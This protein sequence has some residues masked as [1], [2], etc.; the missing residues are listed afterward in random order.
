[1]FEVTQKNELFIALLLNERLPMQDLLLKIGGRQVLLDTITDLNRKYRGIME[2]SVSGDPEE[3][4]LTVQNEDLF[5]AKLQEEKD[6]DFNDVKFRMAFLLHELLK[7]DAYLN[8]ND[9]AETMNVSRGTVN[10]DVKKLKKTLEKYSCRIIG[11]PN[12]GIHFE[13]EEFHKRLVL[14]YEVFDFMPLARTVDRTF[15]EEV[16]EVAVHYGLSS[17]NTRLLYKASLIAAER[18]RK[19]FNLS[20]S[21]PMYKNFELGS[22]RLS[23]LIR[24]LEERSGYPFTCEETDFISFPVNTRNSAYLDASDNSENEEILRQIVHKMIE[25]VRRRFMIHVDEEDFFSKVRYHLL[26]L[27]N[28]LIF[29][30]PLQD[31][32]S[33]QIKIR[34][35][36]AFELARISMGVLQAEYGLPGNY[37]DTSYLAVY[38]ALILDER[39]KPSE[40]RKGRKH[41]AVVTNRGRGTFELIRR[42]LQEIIGEE[43]QVDALSLLDLTK[44]DISKYHILFSTE[45]ILTDV[46]LPV[47]AIDGIIDEEALTRK[48]HELEERRLGYLEQRL[49][50]MYLEIRDLPE[51]KSYREQVADI[52]EGLRKRGYASDRIYDLFLQKESVS[53]MIYENGVAFPHLTDP[54]ATKMSLVLGVPENRKDKIQ[55]IFFLVIPETLVKEEEE[56]LMEIY[57][58][59]FRIVSDKEQVRKLQQVESITEFIGLLMK[60]K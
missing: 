59:I 29:R 30:I 32:F 42:Q 52:S 23:T 35:P 54:K 18:V 5:Y 31:I 24:L 43:S 33:D 11:V 3:V 13:G 10:N 49:S 39:K 38:Y 1:M 50:E 53:S 46:H 28:R 41:V 26:F 27:I 57:D 48:I 51:K 6:Q 60:G 25:Q 34:F 45:N 20:G 22:E 19:G 58:E 56:L 9:L 40:V 7:E 4:L 8:I 17:M 44:K 15:V 36:L 2:I 16:R 12:K 14:L 47:I 37:V 55:L 21:I